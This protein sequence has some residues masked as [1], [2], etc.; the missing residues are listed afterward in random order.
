MSF[1]STLPTHVVQSR[2]YETSLSHDHESGA[3]S[4]VELKG[5]MLRTKAKTDQGRELG[6]MKISEQK[7]WELG[8]RQDDTGSIMSIFR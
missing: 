2:V 3:S 4:W 6:R 5:K 7:V 1:H 8:S